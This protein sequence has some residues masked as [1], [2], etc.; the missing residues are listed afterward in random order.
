VRGHSTP[1]REFQRNGCQFV[2]GKRTGTTSYVNDFDRRLRQRGERAVPKPTFLT[3][4]SSIVRV[5]AAV[6][7][8]A[9]TKAPS[10]GKNRDQA[11]V[12]YRAEAGVPKDKA[13]EK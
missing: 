10:P 1:K 13:A 4:G 2:S 12:R 9:Q 7:V 11:P 8:R 5:Q 3:I 6:I